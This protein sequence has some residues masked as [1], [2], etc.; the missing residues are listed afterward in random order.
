MSA[1]RRI[2]ILNIVIKLGC[3]EKVKFEQRLKVSQSNGYTAECRV[4]SLYKNPQ[5]VACPEY[6]KD[7]EATGESKGKELEMRS[8]KKGRPVPTGLLL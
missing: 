4:N 6:L 7:K 5:I 2:M 3:P 8:E 1:G